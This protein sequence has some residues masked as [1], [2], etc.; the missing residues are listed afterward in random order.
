MV[1]PG[2][3]SKSCTPNTHMCIP[4]HPHLLPTPP[5]I[6]TLLPLQDVAYVSLANVLYRT[7]YEQDAAVVMQLSLEVCVCVCVCVCTCVCVCVCVCGECVRS[8]CG[9][10]VW[11]VSV[12]CVCVWACCMYVCQGFIEKKPQ[13][14]AKVEFI[15]FRGGDYRA[16]QITDWLMLF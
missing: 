15:L 3:Y 6:C 16:N 2:N 13:G 12:C 1:T 11:C 5:H 9:V 10:C 7:G 8:V 14:G 4:T